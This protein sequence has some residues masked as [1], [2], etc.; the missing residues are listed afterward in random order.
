MAYAWAIGSWGD[1]PG[2]GGGGVVIGG[3][4][5]TVLEIVNQVMIRLR[6]DQVSS[7]TGSDYATLV[8]GFLADIHQ[9]LLK[10]E[11]SSMESTVEATVA[12]GARAVNLGQYVADG[13]AVLPGSTLPTTDS[14]VMWAQLFS[15]A[16]DPQGQDL[17]LGTVPGIERAY[18]LDRNST[19]EWSCDIAFRNN[20]TRDGLEAI[21]HP[22]MTSERLL[23]TRVW[24]PEPRINAAT[25]ANRILLVPWRPMYLGALY[26]ALNERGEELGEP[27]GM[28]ETRYREAETV[29][30]EADVNRR[31]HADSYV[32]ERE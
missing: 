8:T 21:L 1:I 5:P 29:A 23:R 2:S 20:P 10:H 3:T 24:T 9:D 16:A 7:L 25:D 14:V 18:N 12:L 28:A 27:G 17:F 31:Q 11:W 30:L 22:P 6:E 32:A 13:G 26:L 15:N 4:A 19:V